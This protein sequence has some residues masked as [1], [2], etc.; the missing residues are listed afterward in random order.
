MSSVPSGRI[1]QIPAEAVGLVVPKRPKTII[2]P[3]GENEGETSLKVGSAVSKLTVPLAAD[4]VN[5]RCV[6]PSAPRTAKAMLPLT[7]AVRSAAAGPIRVVSPLT[8]TRQYD[9]LDP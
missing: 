3:S 2:E 4:A 9:Q 8:E 7:E 5:A 1:V 6:N